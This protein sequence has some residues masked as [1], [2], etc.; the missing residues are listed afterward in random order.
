MR[1]L[2]DRADRG[3]DALDSL[4]SSTAGAIRE[5]RDYD[6][7]DPEAR[8]KFQELLDMLSQRM[9]E[10]SLESMREGLQNLSADQLDDLKDMMAALNR[11]LRERAMKI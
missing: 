2:Q 4:P 3:R 9:M 10:N 6:F 7:V 11:M 5:L 8:Q 1:V